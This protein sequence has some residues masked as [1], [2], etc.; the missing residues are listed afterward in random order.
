MSATSISPCCAQLLVI[1][2]QVSLLLG[3]R[4]RRARDDQTLVNL[5]AI[6]AVLRQNRRADQRL[7]DR[8]DPRKAP[9]CGAKT[10]RG[11]VCQQPAMK[12]GR[13]CLHG[14][15]SPGAPRGE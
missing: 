3:G 7:L 10:R 2:R 12:N 8:F 9:R 5:S 15:K 1:L 14:G 4:R 11:S 13:C 6:A